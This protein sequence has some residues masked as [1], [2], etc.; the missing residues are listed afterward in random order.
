MLDVA[1]VTFSGTSTSDESMIVNKK[2]F[3]P[4]SPSVILTLSTVSNALS[5]F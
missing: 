5:S 2:F 3:V 4:L 1:A